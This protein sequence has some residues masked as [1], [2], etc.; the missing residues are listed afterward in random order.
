MTSPLKA[1][2]YVYF[3]SMHIGFESYF[4]F[5]NIMGRSVAV[6]KRI[7]LLQFQTGVKHRGIAEGSWIIT[8]A[9]LDPVELILQGVFMDEQQFRSL[10]Q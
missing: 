6:L 10:F 3:I 2:S 4:V 8:G 7:N 9:L 5:F 1:L